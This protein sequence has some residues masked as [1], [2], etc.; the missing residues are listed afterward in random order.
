MGEE[1]IM[2]ANAIVPRWS[3]R[4][5]GGLLGVATA[6]VAVVYLV[7]GPLLLRP[8]ARGAWRAGVVRLAGVE[9]VRRVV[10]FG[11]R[12]PERYRAD[13]RKVVRYVA[14]R[15]GVGLVAGLVLGLI[16]FGAVLVVLL[17]AGA[18]RGTLSVVDLLGQVLLGGVLLFLAVQGLASLA[19]SDA[20]LARECFGPSEAELLR[21]RIVELA[22][23]RAAVLHAVDAER[24][25]IER[26]LHDG[27]QQRLVALRLL[28]GRARRGD[29]QRADELLRQAH[30]EA[31]EVLTELREVA[32]RVYPSALDTL[33]LDEALAGLAERCPIPLRVRCPVAGP[34]PERVLTAAYFVVSECVT[35]AA[36]HSSAGAIEVAVERDGERLTVRVEDDG[37]GGADPAGGGLSGLRG[38]VAAL[39]GTLSVHSPAGGPTVV[40]AELPCG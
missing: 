18:L 22:D 23:S 35:N 33:G 30:R 9:R 14:R 5:V 13:D 32:W 1:P 39:D 37:R 26:D 11:D 12:F 6:P 19:E 15:S 36:K 29:P 10:W 38:R 21:R 28:L 34:L 17:A 2:A 3:R 20:R 16:G 27:V 24:R 31:A 7:L 8:W 25:R 40:T 4:A